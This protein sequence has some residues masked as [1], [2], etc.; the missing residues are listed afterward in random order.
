MDYR[1]SAEERIALMDE[2]SGLYLP[3]DSQTAI[4]DDTYKAA[5]LDT[6]AYLEES[7]T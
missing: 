6:L 3:G 2:L 4:L 1:L 5:F 7:V